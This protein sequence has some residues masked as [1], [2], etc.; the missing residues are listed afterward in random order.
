[1]IKE[2]KFILFI[3]A[4]SFQSAKAQNICMV[5]ADY[6]LAET[7]IV[8]WEPFTDISNIDSVF[9][10]RK[11]GEETMF[12]KIGAVDVTSD[13][14]TIFVDETANTRDT[15]K[16]AISIL[17]NL[18]VESGLSPWH[19]PVVLDYTEN[20]NFEWTRYKK[21]DQVDESYIF[22]YEFRVDDTGLGQFTS[23]GIFMNYQLFWFDG[24][25]LIR[26][27]AQYDLLT[28]LPECNF[29]TRANINT[30]RSNIKQQIS[31]AA[32]GVDDL[33]KGVSYSIFPNPSFSNLTIQ[34]E[35]KLTAKVWISTT[36]GEISNETAISNS[37]FVTL[38][39]SNLASGIYFAHVEQNGVVSSMKFVKK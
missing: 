23:M 2:L 30:S 25:Y 32:A 27:D 34:L 24:S 12:A 20:G 9:I 18:G 7:Y 14:E 38:D 31:N 29:Q 26:P 28:V 21:E 35:E 16:Y 33:I 3:T 5:T 17:N 4:F 1:M 8:I 36:K 15:T 6:Q 39:V 19:Q 13:S 10:Y 11:E 22:S 37:D